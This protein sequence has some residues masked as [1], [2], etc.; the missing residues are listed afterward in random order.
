MAMS[1]KREWD[2]RLPIHPACKAVPEISEEELKTL[3]EDIRRKGLE[4]MIVLWREN[5]KL[6]LL[7]GRSRLDAH[8]RLGLPI[9]EGDKLVVPHVIKEPEG[10]RTAEGYVRSANVERRHLNRK[11]KHAT[12]E[13]LLREHPEKSDR[14]IAKE[15]GVQSHHTVT[16]VRTGM[17]S[18][19]QIAQS[20]TTTGG[21]GITRPRPKR[22]KTKAKLPVPPPKAATPA[23][24]VQ[25]S[26]PTPAALAAASG[27]A[28]S[29]SA[30]AEETA[31]ARK[32]VAGEE[33]AEKRKRP[34]P[35]AVVAMLEAYAKLNGGDKLIFQCAM[36]GADDY[37]AQAMGFVSHMDEDEFERFITEFNASV[38]ARMQKLH[39]TTRETEE[40]PE[41]AAGADSESDESD[42]PLTDSKGLP[43]GWVRKRPLPDCPLC[44]GTGWNR[45]HLYAPC[46]GRLEASPTTPCSCVQ[47]KPRPTIEELKAERAKLIATEEKHSKEVCAQCGKPGGNQVGTG[48]GTVR[49]HQECEDAWRKKDGPLP[50]DTEQTK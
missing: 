33:P 40:S 50:T 47:L 17:E 49:L 21:D 20:P 2:K 46:D 29:A 5:G 32:A 34:L 10:D 1:K 16:A 24:T 12:I 22:S 14:Q 37:A 6:S 41:A 25:A 35:P 43:L 19:G 31:A 27:V 28:D 11:Q 23:P 15:A 4:H 45:I 39:I 8:E 18:T 30:S 13:R 7:D 44:E 38:R 3:A 42:G 9:F 48:G 26:E 36:E